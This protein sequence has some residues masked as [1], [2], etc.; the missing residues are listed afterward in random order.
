MR[1]PGTR[2]LALLRDPEAQAGAFP[3]SKAVRPPASAESKFREPAG[4][5]DWM[6]S[7]N[8]FV[9]RAVAPGRTIAHNEA[10]TH[11]LLSTL[12]EACASEGRGLVISN[13]E[14][15]DV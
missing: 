10:K 1:P 6:P 14:Q 15:P 4:G 2:S 7:S 8:V 11:T 13:E 3:V 12:I 9:M 5:K